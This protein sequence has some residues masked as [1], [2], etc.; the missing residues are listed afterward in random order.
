M[1]LDLLAEKRRKESALLELRVAAIDERRDDRCISRWTADSEALEL[2]H[3][4]RFGEA[5]R[6]LGEVLRRSDGPDRDVLALLDDGQ[7]LLLL[8]RFPFLGLARFLVQALIAVE[9]DDAAGGAEQEAAEIEVN[10]G[11][12]EDR[13]RHL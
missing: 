1:T 8:E 13:G 9:L 4:A 7:S 2:L 6:R 10:R 12:V 5:R 11:G 3:Q